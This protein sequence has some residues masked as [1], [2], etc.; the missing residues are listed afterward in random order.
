MEQISQKYK[1]FLV[2]KAAHNK[3]PISGTF[4]LTPLCNLDCKMCYISEKKREVEQQGG[5]L[6]IDFWLDKAKE[7]AAQGMLFLLLTGGEPILYPE[8][9]KLYESLQNMGI[10]LSLNTNG[11]TL[12][13]ETIRFLEKHPPRKL[14]ISIYGASS[15]TYKNLC[16]NGSAFEQFMKNLERLAHTNL[17][18]RLRSVLQPENIGDYENMA[19][20]ADRFHLPLT[21]VTYAFPP[22]RRDCSSVGNN[23]RF[24]PAE[25]AR[26]RARYEKDRRTASE[27]NEYLAEI[28][29]SLK[30]YKEYPAYGETH[31]KC[32]ACLAGFWLNWKGELTSCGMLNAPMV[33]LKNT[34][35]QSGWNQLRT[36]LEDIRLS[37]DC[38]V[39]PK[40]KY[41]N[42]CAASAYTETGAFHQVPQYLCE[43][44][45][46]FLNI[47]TD[48]YRR[49]FQNEQDI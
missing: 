16:G 18:V 9:F 1:D 39:C 32:Q 26:I 46:C 23:H 25:A 24:S 34:D 49:M 10:Y 47:M 17:P 15:D 6:P 44:T 36:Q 20:I 31:V 45:D 13:K 12:N 3:I 28:Q 38:A 40:R 8:F 37:E 33:D 35:F 19:N 21:Y 14:N 29:Q 4:E 7:A 30:D 42:I 27:Y 2:A 11:T 22:T 43:M 41:C 5:L 48:E